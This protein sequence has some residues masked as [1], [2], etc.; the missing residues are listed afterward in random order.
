VTA[1][2]D[3]ARAI[4]AAAHLNRQR[5]EPAWEDLSEKQK[6]QHREMAALLDETYQQE[7][8]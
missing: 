4:A 5:Q 2:E 6:N 1:T 3:M 7:R 8:S